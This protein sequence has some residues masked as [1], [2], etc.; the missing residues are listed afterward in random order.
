MKKYIYTLYKRAK[1]ISIGFVLSVAAIQTA[2]AQ[3]AHFS[4]FF[5]APLLRN[6]A[7]AGL[8]EGD[9]RV[10]TVQ[11]SQWGTVTVPY[12]TGSI[13]AEYKKPIGKNNDYLTLGME[14]MYDK[15]GAINFTT[16]NVMP[17]LN[18]HKSLSDNKTKYLSMGFM[19]GWV[20]RSIDRSKVETNSQFDGYGY[21]PSIP[22]GEPLS[23]SKYT[24]W[25]GSVGM[26]FNSAIAG[27]EDNNYYI[28]VAY[29]H[30][31][32]PLNSFYKD[33]SIELHPKI[34]ASAGVKWATSE[35]SSLTFFA[36][37][38]QQ[39]TYTETVLGG[40]YSRKVGVYYD[41]PDYI[42]HFGAFLRWNDAFIP[43]VKLD[44]RPFSVA[45]SY[46]A[47][48]STLKTASQ[49]Q[50]GFELSVSYVGFLDRDNSTK[51][52]VLCPRF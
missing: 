24:Y 49:S 43:V 9:V 31:N 8:F 23:Q 38:S 1:A 28:G 20:Q 51:N 21:N 27:S 41:Q 32:T 5:E 4:Q 26:S 25:D 11:R 39:G 45:L 2:Q 30:F 33:P 3:D 12:L 34:V 52:A 50:G 7:L 18:Y 15:A 42:I 40:L 16:I 46:D 37:Y 48:I 17:V 13:N 19:G 6:P 36:D 22:D 29:H 44:Y 10:Q 47:N 35:V 14:V